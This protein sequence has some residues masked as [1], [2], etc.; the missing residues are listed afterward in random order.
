MPDIRNDRLVFPDALKALLICLVVLG[1]VLTLKYVG[2]E[3]DYWEN[4]LIAIIYSFHMPLFI[5]IS[6]FFLGMSKDVSFTNFMKKKFCRLL[7]PVI[8]VSFIKIVYDLV[9]SG[10]FL[11]NSLS[12][13]YVYKTMS[14]YWFLDCLLVLS[15]VAKIAS[16][17]RVVLFVIFVLEMV[18][19]VFY[20]DIPSFFLK[21]WQIIRLMPI[22]FAGYYIAKKKDVVSV[23]FE[24]NEKI[25]CVLSLLGGALFFYLC[26]WNL[27]K[28]H[29]WERIMV[30]FFASCVFI[31]LVRVFYAKIPK[32][33]WK[34]LAVNS[35]GIYIL[36]VPFFKLMCPLEKY[37]YCL[38]YSIVVVV[39]TCF[40]TDFLRKTFLKRLLLGE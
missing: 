21:D 1:H 19:V 40:L 30:G 36:H 14:L 31:V 17:N 12:L 32:S 16:A 26:G 6:G 25:L 34:K 22:F 13:G 28:Y 3:K 11:L 18:A 39:V 9:M 38:V 7:F 37:Y 15:F 35:L 10:D 4:P 29:V 27:L 5:A 20:D 24:K 2:V 8:S 23:F 33:F